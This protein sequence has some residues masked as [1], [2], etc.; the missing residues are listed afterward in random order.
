[1]KRVYWSIALLCMSAAFGATAQDKITIT[2]DRAVDSRIPIAVPTCAAFEPEW[3][4]LAAELSQTIADDLRFSGLFNVLSKDRFPIGFTA[5]PADVNTLDFD[6][7]RAT[8]AENL[9]YGSVRVKNGSLVCQFRLFDLFARD[10]LIG[11][12]LS[13]E[14]KHVRLAA[15]RFSEEIIR[16][17]EGT[18]GIGTTEMVFSQGPTGSKEIYVADYDGANPRQVTKHNSISIKPKISPDGQKI[19]YLSYKDRY[20]FLYVFDRLTGASTP[21]SREVGLNSSPAWSP[22]GKRI[23]LT[24]SKDGNTEIYLRDP[25]GKN[26]TRLTKNKEGDTSPSFSPDGRQIAFVSD[27][28]GNAQIYCMNV[29]GSNQRRISFQ[30]GAAYDPAWSPDGKMIAYVAERRGEGLEIYVMNADGA[31]PQRLTD[32]HGSNESPSWSPD[33]RHIMFMSTRGGQAQLWSI[34]LETKYERRV[35]RLTQRGEGPSWG[36]RRR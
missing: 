24:L 22:D 30:G 14:P 7:W 15:H 2:T 16:T 8:K 31:N 25:D 4:K 34:T 21:L 27:R 18:P 26:P 20:S 28:G 12:E 23:A 10:Q 9:V 13:V 29:D 19:A 36:P 32:S 5:L 17:L 1:V 33:N 11:Q 6:S 35:P 3:G